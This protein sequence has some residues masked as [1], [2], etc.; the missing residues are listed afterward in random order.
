MKA[1]AGEP[2]DEP[3]DEDEDEDRPDDADGPNGS[4]LHATLG[5]GAEDA[6]KGICCWRKLRIQH[7]GVI[8]AGFSLFAT[9]M[10]LPVTWQ[11]WYVPVLSPVYRQQEHWAVDRSRVAAVTMHVGFG[12]VMLLAAVLQL[13]APTRKAWPHLH[14]WTG[15][16]Y[17]VAGAGALLALRWL[18]PASGA[19]SARH[20]DPIMQH[21]I[22]VATV[23]W[24]AVTAYGVDAIVRRRDETAHSRAM[25][26]SA[27]IAAQPILQ[28]LL[29]ALLLAPCAMTCAPARPSP[30]DSSARPPCE[31][32]P[33]R[34]RPA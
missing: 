5:L 11:P 8:F 14:R 27:A 16:A 28:R 15:R 18:R 20:A 13:D 4:L 23:A 24:V 21:F 6:P 30:H 31:P 26:L 3:D 7:A 34:A 25:L 9:R 1:A 33:A 19:G 2:N 32:P 29:N 22:D 12:V 10:W 17:V